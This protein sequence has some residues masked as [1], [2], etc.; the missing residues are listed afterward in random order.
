ME[1]KRI[2]IV[3]DESDVLEFLQLFLETNGYQVTTT[4]SCTQAI[5]FV[6]TQDFFLVITDIAMPEMDGYEIISEMT[7]IKARTC[8]VVMTG[9]GY[10]PKHT[11]VRIEEDHSCPCLFKPFNRAK[12]LEVVAKAFER[13]STGECGSCKIE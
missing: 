13:Y 6:R 7:R 1:N 11:L 3:D 10:N 8:Y 2:L 12:V 4:D 5:D 9:F